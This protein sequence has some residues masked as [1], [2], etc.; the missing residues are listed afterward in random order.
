M[1]NGIK[2][3]DFKLKEQLEKVDNLLKKNTDCTPIFIAI[4]GSYSYGLDL[5]ESDIDLKGV[6]IQDLESI[7]KEDKIGQTNNSQYKAQ[8]GGNKKKNS[9]DN[10]EEKDITFYEIGRYIELLSSN[11]PNIL[12]LLNTPEDCIIYKHQIWDELITLLKTIDILSKKCYYSFHN[13]AKQQII[14]ATGLNKKIN[15]PM[16]KERKTPL[17]FCFVII[18][19]ISIPL[20]EYLD[21]NKYNQKYCGLTKIPNCR[22]LYALYYDNISHHIFENKNNVLLSYRKHKNLPLGYGFKGLIKETNNGELV[23]NELRLSSIPN[24][25]YM[26]DIIGT[27]KEF[28]VEFLHN[29]SYNKDGYTTYCKEYKEYYDWILERNEERYEDNNSHN[30]KY[31]G[32]NLSHCLR[33]LYMA[34]EIS[35]GK[36]I[37]V[38]RESNQREELLKVKKGLI[39]Y[40][41]ILKKC[42]DITEKLKEKYE[43]SNLPD[44]VDV[45]KLRNILIQIRKKY[46]AID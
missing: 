45:Q 39:S 3:F 12:E 14:K 26:I 2:N 1:K 21:I 37:I 6:Y 20:K 28:D 36:N 33:L 16:P 24:K 18:E 11:N 17:D 34:N 30:Q 22:D 42:N 19:N 7:L 38:K 31:D 25:E 32:K 8:L 5:P 23:S 44:Y 40:D 46:Y 27:S 35:E 9:V 29:I 15:N 10:K 4:V 41:E 13:Y 43:K